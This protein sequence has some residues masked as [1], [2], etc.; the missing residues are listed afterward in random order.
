MEGTVGAR[1]RGLPVPPV[2]C[3]QAALYCRGMAVVRE[4]DS[5]KGV[6]WSHWALNAR[7]EGCRQHA[8]GELGLLASSWSAL[9]SLH[10]FWGGWPS[11]G[12]SAAAEGSLRPR[13][14]TSLEA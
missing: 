9:G 5:G 14:L 13:C 4:D 6:R 2:L 10:V 7:A 11:R 1:P 3:K 12:P 8:P